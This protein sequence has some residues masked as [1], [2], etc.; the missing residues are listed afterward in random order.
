MLSQYDRQQLQL[1]SSGLQMDDPDLAK[2]LRTGKPRPMPTDRRWPYV[3]LAVLAALVLLAGIAVGGIVLI[4]AGAA[5]LAGIVVV[6]RKQGP[7]TPRV[8]PSRKRARP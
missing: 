8:R 6:C 4:F 5:A 3:I 1:I 7:R 2:A